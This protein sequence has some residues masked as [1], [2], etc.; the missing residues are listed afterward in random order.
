MLAYAHWRSH[1]FTLV[2]LL[3]AISI[4]AIVAVLGWRGLDGVV[5]ARITLTSQIEATRGMQLAFAQMQSDAEHLTDT[6][7]IQS[8]PN[9]LAANDSLIM[10]RNVYHENEPARVQV[11]AYRVADGVLQRRESVATRD[12][13][14]LDAMWKAA[15][16]GTD[17]TP[18]VALQS[19]VLGMTVQTWQNNA[20]GAPAMV[21][22]VDPNSP[23]ASQ[24]ITTPEGLQIAL[25][26]K[27][28]PAALIK[29][30]LLTPR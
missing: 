3:V 5:R 21:M 27:D 14:Q 4:L 10:V 6:A 22:A 15:T 1:G 9:L 12:L 17:T 8:R 20:W 26:I 2:E 25:Q 16:S 18:P 24:V 11:I 28:V 19:G 29:S 23:Q 13:M 7:T 30:F